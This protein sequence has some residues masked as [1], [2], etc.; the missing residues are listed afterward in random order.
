MTNVCAYTWLSDR[1]SL[2]LKNK[3][4][5]GK[6]RPG[7]LIITSRAFVATEFWK[8]KSISEK[9]KI[10]NQKAL[11]LNLGL[12]EPLEPYSNFGLATTPVVALLSYAVQGKG[13]KSSVQSNL[14]CESDF[15]FIA[16]CVSCC[17]KQ[18]TRN[19]RI[20]SQ[21]DN[22]SLCN[23]HSNRMKCLACYSRTTT[24][25]YW[26][27]VLDK[28]GITIKSSGRWKVPTVP[29]GKKRKEI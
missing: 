7:S 28:S 13:S 27:A 2:C 20:Y 14:V 12:R 10:W 8:W 4:G 19:T 22:N 15:Y 17:R 29:Y 25:T 24:A 18:K 21:F 1:M 26:V 5:P 6:L 9:R 16:V 11:L 23:K 3:P